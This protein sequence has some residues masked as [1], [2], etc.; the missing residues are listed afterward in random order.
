MSMF[1][2]G[3]PPYIGIKFANLVPDMRGK[4][5]FKKT[6]MKRAIDTARRAGLTIGRVD[7]TKDGGISIVVANSKVTAAS[8]NPWDEVLT[9]A[10]NEE[11]S[12]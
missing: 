12:A 4:N 3:C 9:D 7:I 8:E 10:A 6:D 2:S 1:L 11:R 5:L